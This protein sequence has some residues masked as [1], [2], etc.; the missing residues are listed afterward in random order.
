MFSF[1]VHQFL[2]LI[3]SH[4]LIFA[5]ISF[6]LGDRSKKKILG[7]M[8]KGFLSMSQVTFLVFSFLTSVFYVRT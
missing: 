7:F 6:I 1:T 5:F 2:S 4:L 8:S 3:R